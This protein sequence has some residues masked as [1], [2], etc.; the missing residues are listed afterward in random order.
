[1]LKFSLWGKLLALCLALVLTACGGGKGSS[2]DAP[3]GFTVTPGNGQ[4]TVTWNAQPG[5]DYWLMYAPTATPIDIANPPL[6]NWA[7]SITSPYVVSLYNSAA[8]VNGT[9]YSFAMNARTGGGPGGAQTASVS[10][11]PGYAGTTWVTG[12]GAA[13]TLNGV[14][15]GTSSADSQNYFAAFGDGGV[16]Y[17]AAYGVSQ[18][19]T[20]YVW[21][22]VMGGPVADFKA[23]TYASSY[24]KFFAVGANGGANNIVSTSDFSNWTAA[25]MLPASASA[26]LNAVTSYGTTLMAVGNSGTVLYSVDGATWNAASVAGAYAG[27][28][29]YGVTY[30]ASN[31]MWVAVGANGALIT[32]STGTSWTS[33]TSNAGANDLLGVTATSGNVVVAVGAGGTVVR[34]LDGG[35]T[36]ALQTSLPAITLYG[37]STDSTQF[38]A[39]GTGGAEFTSLDGATWT[40]AATPGTSANLK[41]VTGS[42][43]LYMAVGVTGATVS[44]IH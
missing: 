19:L 34:S 30:S 14:T 43:S 3:T 4:V 16:I 33:G 21:S 5:V 42:A 1:M 38:V 26:G 27:S 39:V 18:G 35:L 2:A 13:G 31:G 20:G 8:L 23:T 40:L 28:N 29:F 41:A 24:G 44:S 9:V 12:T 6:H 36:W 17:K 22:Q 10:A 37:I 11:T 25:T 7:T 15:F 32:S